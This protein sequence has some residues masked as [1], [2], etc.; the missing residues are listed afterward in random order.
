MKKKNRK[1]KYMVLF[2]LPLL[3]V[4]YISSVYFIKE[5]FYYNSSK[6]FM[7]YI[8]YLT[9]IITIISIIIFT[10]SA[11]KCIKK[12]KAKNYIIFIIFIILFIVGE[13]FINYNLN[14]ISSS[15]KKV[16]NNYVTYSSSLIVL[17]ENKY[18]EISD[19]NSIGII[20]D[21]SNIEG[22]VI[23]K[24]IIKEK[25][26]NNNKIVNYDDFIVM[27][28]D[29]YDKKIDG[30]FVSSSYATMFSSND[31]Y[32]DI[33]NNVT[34]IESKTKK[35][36]KQNKSS[37]KTLKEPFSV[38]LIIFSLEILSLFYYKQFYLIFQ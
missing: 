24:E 37:N 15:I 2:L 17:N 8:V 29:L 19:L 25:N 10:I 31:K 30:V 34:V 16:T 14:K 7:V 3:L 5:V 1:F 9:S 20:S 33:K 36:K 35:L 11:L 6:S 38:L 27:L 28:D 22:Y 32:Q 4:Y 21:K 13:I 12:N 23:P 18:Q 26:I